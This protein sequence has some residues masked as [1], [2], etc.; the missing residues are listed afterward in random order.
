MCDSCSL[1]LS[2]RTLLSESLKKKKEK[3]KKKKKKK[4]DRPHFPDLQR[5]SEDQIQDEWETDRKN[6]RN[7]GDIR[8]TFGEK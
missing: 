4:N 7:D 2:N 8:K 3:K 6:G 1:A 5:R